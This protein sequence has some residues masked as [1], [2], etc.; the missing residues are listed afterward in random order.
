VPPGPLS[1][2]WVGTYAY[3]TPGTT[4]YTAVL[5]VV[6]SATGFSGTFTI[7][8]PDMDRPNTLE[9]VGGAFNGR[10]SL[11]LRTLS[12]R[13]S[14]QSTTFTGTLSADSTHMSLVLP[15]AATTIELQR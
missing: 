4:P 2:T 8:S 10:V 12:G 5:S 6:Q 7:S 11:T 3:N 1:G 15:G 13:P 9:A 14:A